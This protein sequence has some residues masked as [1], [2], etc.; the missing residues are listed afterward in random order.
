MFVLHIFFFF[1]VL[2][3]IENSRIQG[4]TENCLPFGCNNNNKKK[5]FLS[6]ILSDRM[7]G[8]QCE[9]NTFSIIF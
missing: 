7:T 6:F 2:L 3:Q 1:V 9:H 5:R 8:M 4:K